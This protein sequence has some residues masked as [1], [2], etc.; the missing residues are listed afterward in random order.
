[1]KYYILANGEGTRWNNYRGVPKQLIEID[2][3]T[4]LHRMIRLLR[5][6]QVPKEDIVICGKLTDPDAETVLTKSKTKREVFEEIAD[7]A[8]GPFTI[9]YGDC[10]YTEA[11]I[12]AITH[13]PIKTYDE[14][15]TIH[16]N[17]NT[18]CRWAEGYA[19]RCQDCE[20]WKQQLHAINT[21]AELIKTGKDWFI[22]WWLLGVRDERINSHPVECYNP[23]HDIP[24]CDETDDFDYPSDLDTF[25]EVT[26]HK[27]TNPERPDK[28]SVI[29]T[30]YN[31][32]S[33]ATKIMHQ[34]A[35]QK[36]KYYPETELIAIDDGST[37]DTS[38]LDIEGWQVLHQE[39]KG[40]SSARNA[41]LDAATGKYITFVDAD[42]TV[43]DNYLHVVYQTMRGQKCDYATYPFHAMVNNS[44][45]WPRKQ[46]IGNYAVWAYSYTADCIG[47]ARFDET[48]NVAED[49]D[50][51]RKVITEN[52]KRYESSE[53]I[54][55]YDWNANPDSLS[56]RFNRGELPKDRK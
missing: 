9:L 26:G 27:C 42:D 23:D 20:W 17:P 12:H 11:I 18:G 36:R 56:K 45:A 10:Y 19:H 6:E 50:W 44:I 51:L 53:A 2:G 38:Q 43:A 5:Q 34:L 24:W 46:L 25:C 13:R 21:N 32:S 55:N 7:L 41:G 1:M 35:D 3:E 47:T 29:L 48:L 16:P 54:Y 28:L 4:I 14:F 22:H 30:T 33:L 52:K 39:N 15:F 49:V 31:T 37:D 40:V 8:Q